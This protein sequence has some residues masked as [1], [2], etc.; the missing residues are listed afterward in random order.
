MEIIRIPREALTAAD[1]GQRA[2]VVREIRLDEL[3]QQ[4]A[5]PEGTGARNL[6]LLIA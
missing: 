4:S 2:K 6:A 5:A 1:D 3:Q